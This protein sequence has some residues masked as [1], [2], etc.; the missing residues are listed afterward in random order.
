MITST[1]TAERS[2]FSRKL[3][4]NC[5]V[6]RNV[7]ILKCQKP[8]KNWAANNA[9]ILRLLPLSAGGLGILSVLTNRIFS[10][11]APVVAASSSQSRADVLVIAMSAVLVLTGLQWLSLR[12][13]DP[14]VVELRGDTVDY[15]NE[16][17]PQ[18]VVGELKWIWESLQTATRTK[19]M[20]VFYKK[21]CVWQTG[22]AAIGTLPESAQPGPMCLK[23]MSSNSGNYLANLI[24]FPGRRE[25][26]SYL[27]ENM[28]AAIIQPVGNEG[29][30][31]LGSDTQR[32]YTTLD[33]A[34]IAAIADKLEVTIENW[35]PSGTGFS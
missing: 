2:F 8:D 7:I 13:K 1:A 21:R 19:A 18:E 26:T 16:T 22:V 11:V 33:Q 35:A 10:G 12:P 24:L 6:R 29:V 15:C 14:I 3:S 25:F 30:I 31:V 20:V 27:A 4:H 34:W 28:Q 17:L 5:S 32:G 9:H 23:V